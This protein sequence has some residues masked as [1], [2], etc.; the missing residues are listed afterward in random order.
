MRKPDSIGIFM[1][2]DID[3]F[4]NIN[5]TLGHAIGDYFISNTGHIILK[6]CRQTDIVGRFGGDEFVVFM[7][8]CDSE[9]LIEKKA[10]EF[11]TSLKTY[12][13]QNMSYENFS[14]SIG[15]TIYNNPTKTYKEIFNE[16]DTALYDAKNSG[17]DKYC[18]YKE[19]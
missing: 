7:P 15:C 8:G 13:T 17:K 1:I 16:M 12:F 9:S 4:K 11:M 3:N 6:H 19:S 5:D 10:T 2:F 18:I 14:I